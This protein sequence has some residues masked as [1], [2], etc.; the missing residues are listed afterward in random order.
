MSK[1]I[2]LITHEKGLKRS[3]LLWERYNVG[4]ATGSL[5]ANPV[6]YGLG[7]YYTMSLLYNDYSLGKIN[8]ICCKIVKA[9]K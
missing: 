7:T 5:N 1:A 9:G 3:V 8:L 2:L 4:D 6:V